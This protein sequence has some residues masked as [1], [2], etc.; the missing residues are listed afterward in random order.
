GPLLLTTIVYVVEL[1]G[2]SVAT[3]SVLV[4]ESSDTGVTV[5]LSVAL[6]LPGV[7]S[8]TPAGAATLAVFAI[9]PVAP[10]AT[11][12]FTVKVILPPDGS[13]GMTMPA[14]CISATVVFGT[15]GHTAPL[16]ALPQVT[17]VTLRFATAG[18]VNTAP[19]AAEGP[20][21]ATM[22]V[23]VVVPPAL[24]LVTPSV[25]VIERSA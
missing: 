24:I 13:V 19:F 4:I 8:V 21:L 22:M 7:G 5:S 23:Y 14:P 16:L 17:L 6:L 9:V 12:A 20:A 10:P 15:V 11:V 25:L 18:S 2:V 1:P 3:P